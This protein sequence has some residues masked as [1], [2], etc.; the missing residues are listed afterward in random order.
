M[1]R[2]RPQLLRGLLVTVVCLLCAALAAL[3]AVVLAPGSVGRLIGA[4][5]RVWHA[6]T[7]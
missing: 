2:R 1:A 6:G 7:P 5:N 4:P 3:G